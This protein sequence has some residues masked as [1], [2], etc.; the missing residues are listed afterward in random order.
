[1]K[2]EASSRR[3]FLQGLGALALLHCA[4]S[5]GTTTATSSS[6]GS[7]GSNSSGSSSA[8]DGGVGG[9]GTV[10][11]AGLATGSGAF[12]QGKDYG[13]PFASGIG[14]TCTVYAGSTKGPCHSNT[15]DRRDVS[16]GL[17][18]VPTRFE[19]LVVDAACNPV[20]N[21]IVEVW[22][23]SPAGAY[24]RAAQE[25]DGGN[26]Y[27]GSAADLN[28]AFCTGN[29]ADALASNWLR[30]FQTSDANG[31][32]TID[33]I[34]PGWYPGRTAH[35]HFTVTANGKTSVTS[36][37]AFDED[38]TTAIYT[39]HP[40]YASRGDQDTKPATDNVFARGVSAAEAT[41]SF[42]QQEDG[43]VV[44]WKAIAVT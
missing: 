19:F 43:A 21:A 14:A 6:S 38:L 34:F 22:Y 40:S 18:G 15:Y 5:T 7:G 1:M 10:T 44:C 11:A 29:D 20:P 16:D 41:M 8:S 9:S 42:A 32:V 3:G 39:K 37:V 28:V 31:R 17:V 30:G 35:V 24:S 13:N 12:L 36:Q 26:S 2:N 25:I 4:N 27:R 23:A 33:G